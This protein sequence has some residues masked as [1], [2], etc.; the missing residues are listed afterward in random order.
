[1]MIIYVV[2][3]HDTNTTWHTNKHSANPKKLG[4]G[5]DDDIIMFVCARF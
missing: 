4:Y 1:M 5:G 2:L 3:T